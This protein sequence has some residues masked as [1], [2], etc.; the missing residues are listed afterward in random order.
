[1]I[2][3]GAIKD[4]YIPGFPE[5]YSFTDS[6][7]SES[8]TT[9]I[10]IPNTFPDVNFISP[11]QEVNLLTGSREINVPTT[12]LIGNSIWIQLG[13]K[14]FFSFEINQHM[15]KTSN[16][17]FALNTFTLPVPRDI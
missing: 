8:V 7:F 16:I 5:D 6:N 3:T 17:P 11:H 9:K 4:I 2:N 1:L 13:T 12:D 15:P 14:Q 10:S